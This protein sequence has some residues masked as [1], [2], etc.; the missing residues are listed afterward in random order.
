MT[1][2]TT[3]DDRDVA[4]GP[5]YCRQ[6]RANFGAQ[7]TVQ[8]PWLRIATNERRSGTLARCGAYLPE[9]QTHVSEPILVFERGSYYNVPWPDFAALQG[10]LDN[11]IVTTR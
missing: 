2:L 9:S 11:Y 1:V 4:A 6:D 8:L 10:F 5:I 7:T 3:L